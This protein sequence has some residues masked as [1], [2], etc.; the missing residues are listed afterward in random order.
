MLPNSMKKSHIIY[1]LLF[2]VPIAI[3][4]NFLHSEVYCITVADIAL[5]PLAKLIGDSTEHMESHYGTT[6]GSLLNVTF[7]N[8]AGIIINSRKNWI[9]G[10]IYL[11]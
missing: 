8:V 1:I 9:I 10:L 2:A 11:K 3:I 7:G 6:L 5:I 4:L